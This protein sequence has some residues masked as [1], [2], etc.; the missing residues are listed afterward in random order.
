MNAKLLLHFICFEWC[1]LP[2]KPSSVIYTTPTPHVSFT[3]LFAVVYLGH[4]FGGG[5]V[6]VAS[7]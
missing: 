2:W 6:K 4:D 1:A 7:T 3:L 5:D